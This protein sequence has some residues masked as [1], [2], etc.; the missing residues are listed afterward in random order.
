[1]AVVGLFCASAIAYYGWRAAD[2]GGA[3]VFYAI[4]CTVLSIPCLSMPAKITTGG[5]G[6]ATMPQI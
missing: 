2:V 5:P 3:L 1:M 4:A 6:S